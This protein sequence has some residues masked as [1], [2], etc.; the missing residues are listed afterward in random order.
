MTTT[1]RILGW[2]AEGLRCP[3]HEIDLVGSQD[4]PFRISL[5]QMP[6]GTGKTTTL[7]LLR[8]A[9]SGSLQGSVRSPNIGR[10]RK[11]DSQG[12]HGK[13]EVRL[14][15]N[16]R[17]LTMTLEFDFGLGV[18]DYKTTWASGQERE[19]A[20]PAPVR[21]FMNEAFV[22]FFIFDGE[23]ADDLLDP[24]KTDAGKAVESLFQVHLL[25]QMADTIG[26]YWERKT[27][28]S[29]RDQRGLTRSRNNRSIWKKRLKFLEA[30]KQELESSLE[31]TN[32]QIE[33][34]RQ[35]YREAMARHF[36]RE[37]TL[38]KKEEW[39]AE[40][41]VNLA[42]TTR[43]F[44]DEMRNPHALSPTF[45]HDMLAF[46]SS[47]DRVKLP[48]SAAR[49]WFE[50]LSKEGECVCGRPIDEATQK[51]I[52]DRAERYL[53]SDDIFLL[54]R[55]KSDISDSLGPSI[56]QPAEDLNKSIEELA[57]L[58]R[59]Y[60]SANNELALLRQEAKESDPAV[61]RA[62][63][64]M[65]RLENHRDKTQHELDKFQDEVENMP[66][67]RLKRITP[68]QTFSVNIAK[69][70]VD[71]F[72]KEVEERTETLGLKRKRDILVRIIERARDRAKRAI[73]DEI[74]DKTNERIA[75]LMPNNSVQVDKV[76]DALLLRGQAG[77]SAGENLSVAYA[78]L[79]TLFNRAHH[80]QLP[81]VVDSPVVPIDG[82]I[83]PTIGN[84]LP[85]LTGQVIA[86]VISTEREGFLPSLER[87]NEGEIQFITL[88]RRGLARLE[89]RL[90]ALPSGVE[91]TKDGCVVAGRAFFTDFQVENEEPD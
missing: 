4:R 33:H 50:E 14:Q 65:N 66:A 77:G 45:A 81:F 39:V 60:L 40:L 30:R 80:H 84:L 20:P 51:V 7:E 44:L 74:R 87:A 49:E 38:K 12:E 29:A 89:D 13:F 36:I 10:F 90:S 19:F 28:G 63:E 16:G 25:A 68:E 56:R 83:R 79:A 31:K 61:R 55:I 1:L 70:R 76:E 8:A 69:K 57:E 48:E 88:F 18:V 22:N 82:H 43:S 75:E 32:K 52:R 24:E 46:K 3:D 17:P 73:A 42:E 26:E 11:K 37:D 85:R 58:S 59:N 91:K 53:G 15:L 34:Q 27:E 67:D 9:L 21:R 62:S 35:K 5:I 47:L 71:D 41:R 86:F 72:E 78:F 54:N 23:L 6:N 2:K 64:E